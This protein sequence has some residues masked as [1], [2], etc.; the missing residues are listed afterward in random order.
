MGGM[1]FANLDRCRRLMAHK[2]PS[3][4]NGNQGALGQSFAY[5]DCADASACLA[6]IAKNYPRDDF[7]Q[8]YLAKTLVEFYVFNTHAKSVLI[9]FA[10]QAAELYG[11]KQGKQYATA[12]AFVA[13]YALFDNSK[14]DAWCA[15]KMGVSRSTY[16]GIHK[17]K[18]ESLQSKLLSILSIADELGGE[19]WRGYR[20][21]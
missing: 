2:S 16:C 4:F 13:L 21:G 14:N 12:A 19:Y 8:W 1:D 5:L 20:C 3:D 18:I 7:A 10:L 9:N 17:P 11:D 6:Y 15:Q